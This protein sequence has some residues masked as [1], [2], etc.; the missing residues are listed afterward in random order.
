MR[1]VFVGQPFDVAQQGMAFAKADTQL[2]HA[3]LGSFNKLVADGTYAWIIAKW[4]LQSSAI[5]QV[6]ING[7]PAP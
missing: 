2:R 6:A 7:T 5:K 1:D 4:N 3:V